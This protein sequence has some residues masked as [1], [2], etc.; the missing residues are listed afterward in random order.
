MRL[1]FLSRELADACDNGRQGESLSL[2]DPSGIPPAVP[3]ANARLRPDP[4]RR[5]STSDR[6]A[7][8]ILRAAPFRRLSCLQA[9]QSFAARVDALHAG[10]VGPGRR[11]EWGRLVSRSVA[12][13]RVAAL[14]NADGMESRVCFQWQARLT[15]S[16]RSTSSWLGCAGVLDRHVLREPVEHIGPMPA[17]RLSA[18]SALLRES[19]ENREAEKQPTRTPSQARDLAGAKQ[20]AQVRKRFVDPPRQAEFLRCANRYR[21]DSRAFTGRAGIHAL[22]SSA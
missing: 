17:D 14:R 10:S 2:F 11:E 8:G 20:R 18:V 3:L 19:P 4:K 15:G 1:G 6:S 5:T 12:S 21:G 9:G 13:S 22:A 16:S 7:E